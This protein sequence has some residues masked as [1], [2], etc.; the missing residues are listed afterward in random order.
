MKAQAKQL[1]ALPSKYPIY[2]Q[3]I[4]AVQPHTSCLLSHCRMLNFHSLISPHVCSLGLPPIWL[5]HEKRVVNTVSESR[6]NL[7]TNTWGVLSKDHRIY[8]FFS[9]SPS[10][11]SMILK[12]PFTKYMGE[13]ADSPRFYPGL[14]DSRDSSIGPFTEWDELWSNLTNLSLSYFPITRWKNGFDDLHNHIRKFHCLFCPLV[15]SMPE[16]QK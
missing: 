3:R 8:P 7:W 2:P 12:W 6:R 13:P 5:F 16:A 15:F 11:S 9:P 1:H 4:Q 10:T 14:R